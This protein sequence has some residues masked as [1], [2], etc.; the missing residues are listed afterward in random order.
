MPCIQALITGRHA[1]SKV[2]KIIGDKDPRNAVKNTMRSFYASDR[3]DNAFFI[4]ENFAES[5]IERDILFHDETSNGH[6]GLKVVSKDTAKSTEAMSPIDQIMQANA[7]QLALVLIAPSLVKS[8]DWVYVLDDINRQ[9]YNIA[10]VR[11]ANLNKDDLTVLF[12]DLAP[13]MFN[14]DVM[15]ENEFSPE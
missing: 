5:L 6:P 2:Q 13:R 12:K 8:G 1:I 4:S 3:F 14:I 15:W 11:K 9:K 7:N 10:G